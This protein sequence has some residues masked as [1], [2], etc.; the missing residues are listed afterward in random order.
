MRSPIAIIHSAAGA[1]KIEE[2]SYR[3]L[4][5]DV[6]G[7]LVNG[8]GLVSTEDKEAILGM[9]EKGIMISLSTGRVARACQP[10][11]RELGLKGSHIFFDG[12]LIL[13][14]S[15]GKE[16]YSVP[17]NKEIVKELVNVARP[18]DINLELYTTDNL[19]VEKLDRK[20]SIHYEFFGLEPRVVDFDVISE[21]ERVIKAEVITKRGELDEIGYLKDHFGKRLNFSIART[22]ALPQIDFV[23]LVSPEVSKGKAL[24]PLVSYLGVSSDEVVAIGDGL[25]DISL[26]EEAGLGIAM[27][28]APDDLRK[29]ADY[30]TDDAD[31]AGVA[32][33]IEMFF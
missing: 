15:L 7:T 2:M 16:V 6:D 12:S 22:P 28:N 3:L 19:F 14:L 26:L 29:V 20:S 31:H 8:K 30:I 33:A 13:D 5:I 1:A 17:L 9:M 4:V 27:G 23:N 21:R 32:R 24:G 25:N 10:V 11:I 18:R